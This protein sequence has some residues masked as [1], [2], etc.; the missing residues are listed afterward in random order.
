[1]RAGNQDGLMPLPSFFFQIRAHV[2][3]TTEGILRKF[4]FSSPLGNPTTAISSHNSSRLA[5]DWASLAQSKNSAAI[6]HS[7]H[8]GLTFF[9]KEEH[10]FLYPLLFTLYSIFVLL[11]FSPIFLQ[12]LN[13]LWQTTTRTCMYCVLTTVFMTVSF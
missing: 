9:R 5:T 7:W 2:I 4:R 1:M 10:H 11:Q 13:S 8:N 3:I 6:L 12:G